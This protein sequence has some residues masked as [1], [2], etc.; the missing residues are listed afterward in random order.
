MSKLNVLENKSLLLKQVVKC[1]IHNIS[2]YEF[3]RKL[4]LF[5]QRLQTMNADLFG[6][7]VTHMKGT[8]FNEKGEVK[9][10]YEIFV[11]ANNYLD[12]KD[13]FIVMDM[14]RFDHCICLRFEDHPKYFDLAHQKLQVYLYEHDLDSSGSVITVLMEESEAMIKADIFIPIVGVGYEVS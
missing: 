12:F 4:Q 5:I 8:T 14:F 9:A 13:E 7:L 2:I 1:E 11:Q 3:D 6:P 10:D